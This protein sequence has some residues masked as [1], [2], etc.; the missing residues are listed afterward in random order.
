MEEVVAVM[1]S[2]VDGEG[3]DGVVMLQ[4]LEHRME[5]IGRFDLKKLINIK[6]PHP[7]MLMAAETHAFVVHLHLGEGGAE[8]GEVVAVCNRSWV[9]YV[10]VGAGREGR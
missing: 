1:H 8:V 6:K 10:G 2:P 4:M 3:A 5:V 7:L 9:N